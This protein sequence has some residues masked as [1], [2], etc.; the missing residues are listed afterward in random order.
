MKVC[1]FFAILVLSVTLSGCG[2]HYFLRE[3]NPKVLHRVHPLG[4]VIYDESKKVIEETEWTWRFGVIDYAYSTF[5]QCINSESL[6]IEEVLS[7]TPIILLPPEPIVILGQE[8]SG[9]TNLRSIF[10]RSDLFYVPEL[11]HEWLHVYLFWSGKRFLGDPWHRDK[12]FELC[13]NI[14]PGDP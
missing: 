11:R 7:K 6:E 5:K 10:I 3:P 2:F 9:F 12:L 1:S 13:W 8:A 14:Y 4:I